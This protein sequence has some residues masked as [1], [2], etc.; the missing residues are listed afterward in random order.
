MCS[1]N[2]ISLGNIAIEQV[3]FF[4]DSLQG[5][6]RRHHP[7]IINRLETVKR[8]NGRAAA[9]ALAIDHLFSVNN[10]L[11]YVHSKAQICYEVDND[12]WESILNEF[13]TLMKKVMRNSWLLVSLKYATSRYL[14]T[15]YENIF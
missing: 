11:V 4:P 15:D 3:D 8:E 2:T 14:K 13:D 1:F 9:T 7:N 5:E 12:N 10:Q 6:V